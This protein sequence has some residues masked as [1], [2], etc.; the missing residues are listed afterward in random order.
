MPSGKNVQAV[1]AL[2][3]RLSQSAVIISTG[4]VGLGVVAMDELRRAL[5]AKGIE[6]QV[7]RNNLA[8]IAA[9]RSERP[10]VKQVLE[11]PTGLLLSSGDPV[12]TAKTLMDYLRTSRVPLTVRGAVLEDR[13]L[14]PAEVTSLAALPPRPELVA[15]L[16]GQLVGL[17]TGLASLL[18]APAQRL[19]TVL[20]EPGRGLA[21][22]LQ[23]QVEQGQR[24][25]S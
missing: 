9:D 11:G 23:R 13:L 16:A 15:Q 4:F 2:T 12:E 22:V 1:E 21:T 10:Q 19:A 20:N 17:M 8:A 24:A 3:E 14:S 5:R 7:V 18:N 25:T 6:Y